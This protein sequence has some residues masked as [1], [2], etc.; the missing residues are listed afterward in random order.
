MATEISSLRFSETS[1]G[2]TA[3]ACTELCLKDLSLWT[4]QKESKI[5]TH[6][7]LRRKHGRSVSTREKG[8]F[9]PQQNSITWNH[10]E[11]GTSCLLYIYPFCQEKEGPRKRFHQQILYLLQ[12]NQMLVHRDSKSYKSLKGGGETKTNQPN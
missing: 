1:D 6:S 9:C 2:G 8:L 3:W 5:S 11:S 7:C 4:L 12:T 10:S